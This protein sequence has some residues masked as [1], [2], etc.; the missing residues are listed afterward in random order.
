MREFFRQIQLDEGIFVQRKT[1]VDQYEYEMTNWQSPPVEYL[2][3]KEFCK[4]RKWRKKKNTRMPTA[5]QKRSNKKSLECW[6][7]IK[8]VHTWG[9]FSK[10]KNEA[11]KKSLEC[12]LSIKG[13]HTRGIFSK[14]KKWSNKKIPQVLA[15]YK[16]VH[17]WG[18]F[19]KTKKRSNKKIPR[20]IASFL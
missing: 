18:I 3:R 7:S 5:Q 20:M 14:A 13:V 15:L 12:W 10:A 4:V 2:K 19:S 8:G 9:I 6:L 17:T 16:G 1:A 11:T